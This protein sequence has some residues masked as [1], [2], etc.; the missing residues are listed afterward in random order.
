MD[1]EAELNSMQ[2]AKLYFF[3][4]SSTVAGSVPTITDMSGNDLLFYYI[5]YG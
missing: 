3:G 5:L 2:A 4:L 1:S